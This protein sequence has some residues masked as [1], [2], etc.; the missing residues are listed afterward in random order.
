MLA[1][2]TCKVAKL[3][4]KKCVAFKQIIHVIHLAFEWAVETLVV[5][6]HTPTHPHKLVNTGK[7]GPPIVP[8]L[9]IL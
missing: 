2:F 3:A 7:R 8:L 6:T 1:I 4:K 5:C 9:F